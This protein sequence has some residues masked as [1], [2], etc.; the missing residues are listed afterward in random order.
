MLRSVL[1]GVQP[2]HSGLLLL[3]LSL[4]LCCLTLVT[5]CRCGR[6]ERGSAGLLSS[7]SVH[8]TSAACLLC[9]AFSLTLL[10]SSAASTFIP[11]YSS[12]WPPLPSQPA[13]HVR[14]IVLLQAVSVISWLLTSDGSQVGRCAS[15][16]ALLLTE[17]HLRLPRGD[18]THS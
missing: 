14:L 15:V 16:L 11:P 1:S 3:C 18:S 4:P 5:L 10:H 12:P 9:L 8:L 6:V 13:S 7:L 2:L 17:Q